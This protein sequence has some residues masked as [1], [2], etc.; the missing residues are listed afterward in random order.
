MW[1]VGRQTGIFDYERPITFVSPNR[2]FPMQ[3]TRPPRKLKET[4]N[5]EDSPTRVLFSFRNQGPRTHAPTTRTVLFHLAG[6]MLPKLCDK[7]VSFP[8][9]RY[10]Q[11]TADPP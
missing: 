10:E 11:L 9:A 7:L 3:S 1:A 8:R 5:Q 4:L 2:R 6:Q